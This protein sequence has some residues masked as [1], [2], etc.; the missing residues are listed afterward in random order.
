MVDD[1]DVSFFEE[2]DEEGQ[3]DRQESPDGAEPEQIAEEFLAN[4]KSLAIKHLTEYFKDKNLHAGGTVSPQLFST[5]RRISMVLNYTICA[6]VDHAYEAI[7]MHNRELV[8]SVL[9]EISKARVPKEFAGGLL[10]LH[11]EFV[12]G[13]K[14]N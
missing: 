5:S 3:Q 6:G 7:G 9:N 8:I 13:F 11:L 1:K 2:S 4:A 12:E 14:F 10:C